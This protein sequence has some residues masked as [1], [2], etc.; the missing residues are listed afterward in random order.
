M[1]RL[2]LLTVLALAAAPA[3]FAQSYQHGRIR[4][5]EEGVSIQ[6]AT[7]TG[8]EEAT[9]N[10]P[11][12][13]GDRVWTDGSGRAEFQ[14]A[15]GSLLRLDSASKLD[16]AAHEEGRDERLVL[17]LWSG[18][19]YLHVL[20]R[21]DGPFEF[22]TPGGVVTVSSRAVVR[23][24]VQSGE[25]R[26]S[27]YEGEAALDGAQ[28]VRLRAGERVYARR[29][30]I[31]EEPA[32]FDRAEGD[33]FAEWDDSR[34]ER[35]AYAGNQPAALPEDVAPYA[36]ELDRHGAWYYETEVGHVWRPYVSAGWQ[37]YS[38]GRW[39]WS[40]YGWT[41]VPYE[42][43]GWAPSHY[44]RWGFA[45][46]LGWYWIPGAS[47]GPAWVSWAAGGDYV[48]WCPLGYRDR[49]IFVHDRFGRGG[50]AVPRDSA[51]RAYTPWLY[52][53]RGDVGARDL[54]RRRV[55]LD[56]AAVQ[57]VKILEP[58]RV[59]LT[60]D[61]VVAEAPAVAVSRAVP[62][63]TSSRPG[64]SDTVPEMRADPM[65]TIPVVRRRG[66][67]D[68]AITESG[69][70]R[71]AP[72]GTVSR[73]GSASGHSEPVTASPG[74]VPRGTH[75]TDV[76]SGQRRA[77]EPP[78]AQAIPRRGRSG[79]EAEVRTPDRPA[80]QRDEASEADREVLRPMFRPLGRQRDGGQPRDDG[81]SN[82]GG[83]GPH[84][85]DDAGRPGDSGVRRGGVE[86]RPAGGSPRE[87]SPREAAP[88]QAAPPPRPEPPPTSRS[89]GGGQPQAQ[90]RRE[91][92]PPPPA[93]AERH[94]RKR[95]D[96]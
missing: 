13:P 21:R 9:P 15:G 33:E 86:A 12:L 60:R 51:R 16:Y 96:Q 28:A 67:D 7:E 44:G 3:L 58:A 35:T 48:G 81:Q 37:P 82:D 61:L 22:E 27:V 62:R 25:T 91:A 52:L 26:V 63:N 75:P 41:W 11:F 43:W 53:R 14:F 80:R 77:E 85:G 54:T 70:V 94:P 20:D 79:A 24:D 46:A 84:R 17:R 56:G 59:R 19:V 39:V 76:H 34:Q 90:P 4:H 47:W 72:S 32:A 88:R 6:R 23:I 50:N 49:P 83:W 89:G 42:S 5:I 55:Q 30:E 65:T 95:G 2:C 68:P 57:Q 93:A 69:A 18:A 73:F 64:I 78:E 66:R 38:N 36:G 87:A 31:T 8:A 45:P 1:R 29:G 71:S 10:L 74:A 40:V 92:P